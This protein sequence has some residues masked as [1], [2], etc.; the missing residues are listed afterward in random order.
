LI[1]HSSG[2]AARPINPSNK[3]TPAKESANHRGKAKAASNIAS[4][5]SEKAKTPQ[6]LIHSGIAEGGGGSGTTNVEAGSETG[7]GGGA[8]GSTATGAGA[9]AGAAPGSGGVVTHHG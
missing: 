5:A 4:A 9:G 7:G 3:P 6:T 8:G 1:F 2:R